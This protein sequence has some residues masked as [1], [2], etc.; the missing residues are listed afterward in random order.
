MHIQCVHGRDMICRCVGSVSWHGWTRVLVLFVLDVG[1]L[2]RDIS[3]PTNSPN[4]TPSTHFLNLYYHLF[5]LLSPLISFVIWRSCRYLLYDRF[6]ERHAL[7][8]PRLRKAEQL[9]F[10]VG[11]SMTEKLTHIIYTLLALSLSLSLSPSLSFSLSLPLSLSLSLS[12]SLTHTYP[13]SLGTFLSSTTN[14][15]APRTA[16]RS[17]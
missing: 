5:I 9:L 6:V 11:K 10:A 17:I 7:W 14:S 13:P 3:N 8:T 2:I 15:D 4:Y 12:L 16:R 1:S